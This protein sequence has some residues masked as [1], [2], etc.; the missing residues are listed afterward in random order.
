MYHLVSKAVTRCYVKNNVFLKI[1]QNF[2]VTTCAE[3][4]F[5]KVVGAPLPPTTLY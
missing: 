4:F 3:V 5:N 1:S 2:Q